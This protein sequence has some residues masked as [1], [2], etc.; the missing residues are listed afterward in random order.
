M[1]SFGSQ[2]QSAGLARPRVLLPLAAG[3]IVG[4]AVASLF[5]LLFVFS[6]WLRGS[7]EPSAA[8]LVL[9]GILGPLAA[10][11]VFARLVSA[12]RGDRVG[13]RRALAVGAAFVVACFAGFVGA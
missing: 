8:L 7:D 1:S 13:W 11:S 4:A 9:V 10:G 5:G 3:S 12:A 2:L 6:A